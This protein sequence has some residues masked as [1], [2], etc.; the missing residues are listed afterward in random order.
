MDDKWEVPPQ[1]DLDQLVDRA[2]QGGSVE[3]TRGGKTIARLVP[4]P[5]S[6][7]APPSWDELALL[8]GGAKLPAGVTIKDLINDG[9]LE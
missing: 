4:V 6:Q 1:S 5:N 3:L 9:R 2:A 8:R 7:I